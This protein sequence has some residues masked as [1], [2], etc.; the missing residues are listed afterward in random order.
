MDAIGELAALVTA[1]FSPE[2]RELDRVIRASVGG[3][4][5][6]NYASAGGTFEDAVY[7]MFERLEEKGAIPVFVREV[8]RVKSAHQLLCDKLLKLCPDAALPQ[9][10]TSE[11]VN[12]IVDGL[13]GALDLMHEPQVRRLVGASLE[14][15]T[16][17]SVGVEVLARYKHLHDFLHMIQ[18]NVIR[19]IE[20]AVCGFRVDPDQYDR[21]RNHALHVYRI[22]AMA[23]DEANGLPEVGATR[24][25]EVAWITQLDGISR[26]LLDALAEQDETSAKLCARALRRLLRIHPHRIDHLLLFTAEQLELEQIVDT[27]DVVAQAALPDDRSRHLVHSGMNSLRDIIPGFM[28]R[29][30]EHKEWQD[31]ENELCALEES[32]QEMSPDGLDMFAAHWK[33]VDGPVRLL[34][35]MASEEPWSRTLTRHAAQLNDALR[36]FPADSGSGDRLMK[37]Q[38][39]FKWF[40]TETVLRFYSVD[41]ALKEACDEITRI[42]APLRSLA[43]EVAHG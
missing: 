19:E 24:A 4:L 12:T 40:R 11:R 15:L 5:Y 42:S 23:R 29:V 10:S 9:P 37:V 31:I 33:M 2:T 36:G 26:S 25:Q 27:L 16:R 30:H 17:S 32:I 3:D 28:A 39:C 35:A 13:H 7:T 22:A 21:L 34:C 18:L 14:R 38:A 43:E 20:A 1:S 8:V 41:R 6:R